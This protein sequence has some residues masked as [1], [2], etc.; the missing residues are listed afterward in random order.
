M[1]GRNIQCICQENG[2]N[3]ARISAYMLYMSLAIIMWRTGHAR[4]NAGGL[5][6]ALIQGAFMH[7]G[8]MT[9]PGL[10]CITACAQVHTIMHNHY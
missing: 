7:N 4:S 3:R 10:L 8:P 9:K 5:L 6:R 2:I 1:P